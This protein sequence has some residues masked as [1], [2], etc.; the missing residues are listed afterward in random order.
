MNRVVKPLGNGVN[1]EP[2]KGMKTKPAEFDP[3][4]EEALNRLKCS[5]AIDWLGASP[6]LVDCAKQA[7]EGLFSLTA[8]NFDK[9]PLRKL[10]TDR[11]DAEQIWQQ[12]DLQ[13]LPVLSYIRRR[14]K[15]LE[16]V[17]VDNYFVLPEDL[18]EQRKKHVQDDDKER[19]TEFA[20]GA[21]SASEDEDE[22]KSDGSD[23]DL[24]G[25]EGISGSEEEDDEDEEQGAPKNP[26]EDDFFKISE[27]ENFLDKADADENGLPSPSGTDGE[28]DDE[29]EDDV[30]AAEAGFS[31]EDDEDDE[32]DGGGKELGL[33]KYEEFFGKDKKRKVK[34]DLDDRNEVDDSDNE[35]GS[36]EGDMISGDKEILLAQEEN[37]SAH[38]KRLLKA[39][40]R[41]EY[42]EKAN[43]DP[44]DWTQQGEVT[45]KKRPKNSALEVEL[46]F[47]HNARP[48]P[49]ITEE[50]TASL[51]DMIKARIAEGRFDD[52]QRRYVAAD[53]APKERIELDENK[54]Q[55]G[56]G[57]L[58]EADYMQQTG[59]A[60]APAT[61]ND[62]LRSEATLLFKALCSR[63]DA[64]S[65]FNFAPKPVIEDMGVRADVP[66]L[67][68]E[69]VAPLAVSDASMLAPE[70]VFTGED[71]L[72]AEAELTPEERK[73]RRAQKKRKRKGERRTQDQLRAR[74]RV[75]PSGS[76]PADPKATPG[77]KIG[78]SS[79]SKSTKVFAAL[80]SAKDG[81]GKVASRKD[82]KQLPRASNLKL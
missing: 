43:I 3:G 53:T 79:F 27:M 78:Y 66:A 6:A 15:I 32:E 70:E 19:E 29:D 68:M 59:S 61:S 5:D 58:Y 65:H 17:S 39:K 52:I 26:V 14:V 9:A 40:K 20:N 81:K 62:A 36:G 48:P 82:E 80:D 23:E 41:I 76:T 49:V 12:I 10:Y 55:K 13:S 28:E 34:F 64:L 11:F 69:E 42:F 57:E 74:K 77:L 30:E 71:G 51:E 31:E 4:A 7:S 72:K 33:G 50:V 54:S 25:L 2:S 67:A 56:L 16:K 44:K 35:D 18:S 75:R 37:L 24:D 8:S 60:V 45:A 38:E 47:D 63:L 46:D 21:H 73:R 1:K 22:G